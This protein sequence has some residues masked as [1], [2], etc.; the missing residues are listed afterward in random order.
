MDEDYRIK[1]TGIFFQGFDVL[2]L[3]GFVSKLTKKYQ[4]NL[5]TD[6]ELIMYDEN[7]STDDKYKKIRK[8]ILDSTNNFS[9]TLIKTI[10]G[11]IETF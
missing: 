4:A 11:D 5:L 8:L 3:V 7:I 9:R 10:F 6:V 2:D 1:P